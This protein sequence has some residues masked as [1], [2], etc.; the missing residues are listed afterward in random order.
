MYASVFSHLIHCDLTMEFVVS[1]VSIATSSSSSPPCRRSSLLSAL[2]SYVA[3]LP[4][5][6]RLS[7]VRHVHPYVVVSATTLEESSIG[8][9][10]PYVSMSPSSSP[11]HSHLTLVVVGSLRTAARV[12]RPCTPDVV[13]SGDQ[14]GI[15]R[16]RLRTNLSGLS[17]TR[18]T[19]KT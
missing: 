15:R 9:V 12:S 19:R 11:H 7:P 13:A 3:P 17:S 1:C 4:L 5:P 14:D 2:E 16:R 8:C 10:Q 18:S 6:P